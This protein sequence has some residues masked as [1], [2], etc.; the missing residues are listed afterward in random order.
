M[1]RDAG[2]D[3]KVAMEWLGHADEKMILKIYDHTEER[4]KTSVERLTAFLADPKADPNNTTQNDTKE[5]K[6]S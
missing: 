3:L 6:S 5:R 2:V 1:L 4:I